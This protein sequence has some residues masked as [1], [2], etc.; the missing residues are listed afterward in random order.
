MSAS[1]TLT[2][3]DR[4]LDPVADCLPPEVARRII[5]L[6]MD[7]QL[8]SR[9]DELAE[10]SSAGTLTNEE[11]DEYQAYVEGMDIVGLFKAKA[12]RSLSRRA[13]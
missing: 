10:K 12:R 7:P 8:Q 6:R 11:R 9:L 3:L 13:S 2:I 1:A 4:F 5:D